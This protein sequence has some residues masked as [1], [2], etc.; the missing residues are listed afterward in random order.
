MAITYT[1]KLTGLKKKTVGS[2]NDYI[3]Q[4]YWKKTGTD[5][6]GNTGEFTGATPF[7]ENA[8]A[9]DYIAWDQLTEAKVLEWIQAVVTGHYEQHVNDKIQ[10]QIDAK[11][12]PHVEVNDGSFPW[13]PP[14][15]P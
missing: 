7:E 4:T 1:W 12:S 9:T 11:V 14:K 15:A 5:E 6:N 10:K 2:F 3:V 13:D 8:E